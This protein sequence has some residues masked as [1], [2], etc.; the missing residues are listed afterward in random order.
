MPQDVMAEANA[1][2]RRVKMFRYGLEKLTD[3]M[4]LCQEDEYGRLYEFKSQ[5][6]PEKFVLVTNGTPEPDGTIK[7]YMLPTW[8]EVQ[9][10]HEA[11][12][13]SYSR[14]PETYAPVVRT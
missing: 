7:D 6:G 10:A 12:S 8:P 3:K 11:V 14:T 4:K 5:E 2:V 13:R 9:T 1:E